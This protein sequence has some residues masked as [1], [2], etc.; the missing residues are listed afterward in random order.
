MLNQTSARQVVAVVVEPAAR[1]LL[2]L[3]IS[4]AAITVLGLLGTC[5]GA[6]VFFPQ[7]RFRIPVIDPTLLI[8]AAS[9][10]A[11][12]AVRTT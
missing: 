5:A 4:P 8:C 3:G 12:R 10:W 9:W 1:G 11:A 6:L 2:R 7:E